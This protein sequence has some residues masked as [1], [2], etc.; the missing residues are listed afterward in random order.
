ME[1]GQFELKN[2]VD[3]KNVFKKKGTYKTNDEVT[4]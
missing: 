3:Q 2:G 1:K 4:I